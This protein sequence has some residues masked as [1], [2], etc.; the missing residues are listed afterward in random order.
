[1]KLTSLISRKYKLIQNF[2]LGYKLFLKLE[3]YFGP[4]IRQRS[5]IDFREMEL[6]TKS[7][8]NIV[9]QLSNSSIYGDLFKL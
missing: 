3:L 5:Q 6:Q 4:H 8:S 7:I 2:S 1:M 9:R